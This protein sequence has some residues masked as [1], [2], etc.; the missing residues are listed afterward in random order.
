MPSKGVLVGL[1]SL[2]KAKKKTIIYT[3]NIHPS[4]I[5]VIIVSIIFSFIFYPNVMLIILKAEALWVRFPVRFILLPL[6]R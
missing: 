6:M 5:I 1:H 3:G 4:I 2:V